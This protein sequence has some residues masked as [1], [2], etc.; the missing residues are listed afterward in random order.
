MWTGSWRM[1]VHALSIA[2]RP[3]SKALTPKH[4]SLV[5]VALCGSP[6]THVLYTAWACVHLGVMGVEKTIFQFGIIIV[7]I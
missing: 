5:S 1:Q 2:K 7:Y 4:C 3:L 6:L